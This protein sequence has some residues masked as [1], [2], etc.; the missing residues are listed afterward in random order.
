MIIKKVKGNDY[1]FQ[2][3]KCKGYGHIDQEQAEGKISIICG[4]CKYHETKNWIDQGN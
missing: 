3:P 1:L 4:F 2:C